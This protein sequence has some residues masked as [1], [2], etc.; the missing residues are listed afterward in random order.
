[1]IAGGLGGLGRSVVRWMISRNAKNLIL[2]SRSGESSAANA[3]FLKEI[4]GHNIRVEAP[5][6]DVRDTQLV[7]DL[8]G[9]L[10]EQKP[11]VK[12]C[13]QG[14]MAAR[15]SVE[16]IPIHRNS[17]TALWD[18]LFEKMS[19]EDWQDA[20]SCKTIGS[21]NLHQIMPRGMDFFIL[22]S[23]ASVLAGIGGQANYN[24]GN[25]YEDA[26]ARYRVAHGEKAVAM[27]LGAMSDDGLLAENRTLLSRVL[28]YG[29]LDP[30]RREEFFVILDYH[31]DPARPI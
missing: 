1:M 13:V 26:L 3:A 17:L 20:A 12:G 9:R 11:P 31:C 22:L 10:I 30:V 2:L 7:Q 4:R 27:D 28:Q 14:S 16:L 6:C 24:A 5:V 8:L 15:V 21:W 25:A 18:G 19:M 29:V 23:S